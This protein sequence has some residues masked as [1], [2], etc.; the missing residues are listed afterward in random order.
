MYNKLDLFVLQIVVGYVIWFGEVWCE[1]IIGIEQIYGCVG[2]LQ[3][4]L[5][6]VCSVC[7]IVLQYCVVVGQ[8]NLVC[9][10]DFVEYYIVLCLQLCVCIVQYQYWFVYCVGG[11]GCKQVCG[12]LLIQ[13]CV[14]F[15]GDVYC[16]DVFGIE[17]QVVMQ[18][19]QGIVEVEI[20]F[21][22]GGI[23]VG[24]C[25]LQVWIQCVIDV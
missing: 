8:W 3:G 5:C 21:C 20:L 10:G 14:V 25:C 23:E 7:V 12:V 9:I 22:F 17:L 2:C 1:V 15:Q 4:E 13:C 11:V 16:I 19:G 6:V 18:I 24:D